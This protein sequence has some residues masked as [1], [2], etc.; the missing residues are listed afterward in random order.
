MCLKKARMEEVII[1]TRCRGKFRFVNYFS[2]P[3]TCFVLYAHVT[4]GRVLSTVHAVMEMPR[5]A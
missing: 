1:E 3:W 2:A 4:R 5:Q